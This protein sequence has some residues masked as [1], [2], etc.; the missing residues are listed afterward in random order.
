MEL[1]NLIG[2]L[3]KSVAGR[4]AG[5]IFVVT[6]IFNKNY[7]LLV[8]GKIRRLENPKKKKGKHVSFQDEN[9]TRLKEKILR[10]EKVTHAE[11]RRTILS[12][13]AK[14]SNPSDG[15]D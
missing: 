7:V 9:N 10:K 15:R 12:L 6:E 1:E 11:I 8:D 2:C 4:D 5:K 14:S 13:T 3:V